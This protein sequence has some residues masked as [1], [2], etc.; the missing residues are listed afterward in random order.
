MEAS[1]KK[2]FFG[3]GIAAVFLISVIISQSYNAQ[4]NGDEQKIREKEIGKL[5]FR[6]R[7]IS[8]KTYRY[9][10]KNYLLACIKLD[11]ANV[12]S[13][14]VYNDIDCIKIKNGIATMPVGYLNNI[15][16]P[17][18]SVAF[19]INNSGKVTFHYKNKAVHQLLL[20]C[21]PFGLPES[22]LNA[23]N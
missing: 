21:D 19:N 5:Q 10:G 20:G 12:K 23:C 18:D 4:R 13:L 15:L 3:M 22:E 8:S 6:G 7:V 1:H 17:V 2:I 16:G 9:F 14:Y 11:S